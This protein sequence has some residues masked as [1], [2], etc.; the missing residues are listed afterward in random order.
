M[1]ADCVIGRNG[2]GMKDEALS[3]PRNAEPHPVTAHTLK[4]V[5]CV[6]NG[7]QNERIVVLKTSARSPKLHLPNSASPVP[8]PGQPGL[9]CA[10]GNNYAEERG[11]LSC[12]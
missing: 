2:S 3:S 5:S 6:A 10:R 9:Q 8:W 1:V 12:V 11:S 4:I 7:P